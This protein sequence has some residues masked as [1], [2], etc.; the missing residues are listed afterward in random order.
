[1]VKA[2]LTNFDRV[3]YEG[4]S[5]FDAMEKAEAAG[6]EVTILNSED[7]KMMSYSPVGGW[8]FI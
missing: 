6:F 4:K 3:I 5:L 7:G 2:Y 8:R 1:M